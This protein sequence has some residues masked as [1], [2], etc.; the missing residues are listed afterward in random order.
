MVR[1]NKL[2][3]SSTDRSITFYDLSP[4]DK[5]WSIYAR[6]G[7]LPF[8]PQCLEYVWKGSMLDC[9]HFIYGDNGGYL[10]VYKLGDKWHFWDGKLP[11]FRSMYQKFGSRAH[12]QNGN[13]SGNM[14]SSNGS[15]IKSKTNKHSKNNAP[16]KS[17][18]SSSQSSKNKKASTKRIRNRGDFHIA[19]LYMFSI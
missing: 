2:A 6:M 14:N 7:H 9:E 15:S 12:S 19:F 3:V 13:N 8:I 4:G 16:W 11:Q 5:Q 1:S 10:N 17:S 18:L